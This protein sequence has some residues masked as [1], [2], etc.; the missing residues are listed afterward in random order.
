MTSFQSIIHFEFI[1]INTPT[2]ASKD[3]THLV[4]SQL[5]YQTNL[6]PLHSTLRMSSIDDGHERETAEVPAE[7]AGVD[8]SAGSDTET[9]RTLVSDTPD[10]DAP[11]DKHHA[12]S[13]SVKKPT[14][15]KAVSVTKNFLA[16]AGTTSTPAAKVNGDKG[17]PSIDSC[18]EP[19]A[20][21]SS[22][23][24]SCSLRKQPPSCP[25]PSTCRKICKWP[26]NIRTKVYEPGL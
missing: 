4:L 17:I 2:K 20:N 1:P 18:E 21:L 12:R 15:F 26:P 25:S 14:T 3:H 16:K 24:Y 6:Q 5:K 19:Q 11:D 9:T 10:K 7:Q 8:G 22:C 23:I 13:N